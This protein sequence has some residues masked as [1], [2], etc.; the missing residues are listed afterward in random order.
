M[1]R[2]ISE[3]L[4]LGFA[5]AYLTLF[6]AAAERL[7]LR[8]RAELLNGIAN[9]NALS[10]PA[11]RYVGRR[12]FVYAGS[13]TEACGVKDF[14]E[15][16]EM[17]LMEGEDCEFHLFGRGAPVA[18]VSGSCAG[19]VVMHGFVPEQE[20]N[21]FL[22]EACIGVEPRRTEGDA[23]TLN[24]PYKLLFYLSRGLVT[25]TTATG[26]VPKDLLDACL[27]TKG[28]SVG[29]AEGM[30]VVLRMPESELSE[31]ARKGREHVLRTRGSGAVA[32]VLCTLIEDGHGGRS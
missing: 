15:A 28:G 14:L 22:G 18:R 29:L 13:M 9:E 3:R 17:L 20:L 10:C 8:A 16:A 11:T 27:V 12:R 30:R 5:D 4:L 32:G 26:G 21:D 25:L 1:L 7:P 24:T 19:K 2:A 6:P 31:I 23:N